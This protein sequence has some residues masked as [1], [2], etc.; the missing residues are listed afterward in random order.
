MC[1]NTGDAGGDDE[2]EDVMSGSTNPKLRMVC[3]RCAATL[4]LG[5]RQGIEIDYCP[6]CRGVWLDSGELDKL[7]DRSLQAFAPQAARQPEQPSAGSP[8]LTPGAHSAD[9][10]GD[11]ERSH[12]HRDDDHHG[13][14]QGR[15]RSWLE[16][17]FD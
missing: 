17:L 3:P 8:W 4:A 14:G 15:R 7:I 2:G 13:N 5:E 12:D 16:N 10:R 9:Y 1:A 6:D 11:P